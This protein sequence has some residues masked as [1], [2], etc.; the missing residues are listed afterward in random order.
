MKHAVLQGKTKIIARQ[1]QRIL[2]NYDIFLELFYNFRQN[3][4]A[5][6]GS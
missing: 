6:A 5:P 2:D 3:G 4:T 1:K